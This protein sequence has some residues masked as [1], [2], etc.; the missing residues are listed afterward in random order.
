M[1]IIINIQRSCTLNHNGE[2]SFKMWMRGYKHSVHSIG[3][4]K[5]YIPTWQQ[6]P[7]SI[8]EM[9]AP[10]MGLK[11]RSKSLETFPKH[12]LCLLLWQFP[13]RLKGWIIFSLYFTNLGLTMQMFCCLMDGIAIFICIYP[14]HLCDQG[15]SP[16]HLN[17]LPSYHWLQRK[18]LIFKLMVNRGNVRLLWVE[19]S[20]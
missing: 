20:Q 7:F 15:G 9:E 11:L 19:G 5:E 1:L 17:W 2:Y 18:R 12:R 14:T 4:H 8:P 3:D 6:F 16:R 13:K 10:R